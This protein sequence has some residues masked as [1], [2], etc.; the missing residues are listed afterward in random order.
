MYYRFL[1]FK[2]DTAFMGLFFFSAGYYAKL[3]DIFSELPAKKV[4][5]NILFMLI[6]L[7]INIFFGAH[8]N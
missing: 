5:L 1:P 7:G 4:N 6:A 3:V 2:L 8:L